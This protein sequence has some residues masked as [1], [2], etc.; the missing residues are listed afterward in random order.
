MR[1]AVTKIRELLQSKEVI[2]SESV[3]VHF[4]EYSASSLDIR[5]ICQ[6][7]DKDFKAFMALRESLYLEIMDIVEGLGMSF[8][9]PSQSLYIEQ[10]PEGRPATV[11]PSDALAPQSDEA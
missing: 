2:D 9:Y 1:T 11:E 8:A 4:V 5:L 7:L 10:L 6:V 3:I